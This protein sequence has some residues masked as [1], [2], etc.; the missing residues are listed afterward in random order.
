MVK[1]SQYFFLTHT[2]R[3]IFFSSLFGQF[4]MECRQTSK[5][6]RQ[7]KILCTFWSIFQEVHNYWWAK[8]GRNLHDSFFQR[9]KKRSI[10]LRQSCTCS[11]VI[12]NICSNFN[13]LKAYGDHCFF[14]L[15]KLKLLICKIRHEIFLNASFSVHSL[16]KKNWLTFTQYLLISFIVPQRRYLLLLENSRKKG[17]SL[18]KN[19]LMLASRQAYFSSGTIWW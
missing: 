9:S 3:T 2:F 15:S 6:V 17:I 4:T 18:P 16:E 14:P 10:F 5:Q 12:F 8:V 11:F 13:I 19:C 7:N 1:K